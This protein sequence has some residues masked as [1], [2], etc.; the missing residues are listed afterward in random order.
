TSPEPSALLRDEQ[1]H[2][3]AGEEILDARSLASGDLP[4]RLREYVAIPAGGQHDRR[5]APL[6]RGRPGL[7]PNAQGCEP[8]ADDGDRELLLVAPRERAD[9]VGTRAAR[10]DRRVRAEREQRGALGAQAQRAPGRVEL[11]AAV[12][13]VCEHVAE[14]LRQPRRVPGYVLD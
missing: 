11:R 12:R 2:G 6:E 7:G 8:A 9:V 3:E 14:E 10:L 13:E 1:R 4:C 5:V